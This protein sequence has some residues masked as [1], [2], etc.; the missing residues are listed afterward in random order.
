MIEQMHKQEK[1]KKGN[2][3]F[4]QLLELLE[5]PDT[6]EV[7]V[8]V[9]VCDLE[10]E[11]IELLE[12]AGA[13]KKSGEVVLGIG[14]LPLLAAGQKKVMAALESAA[15]LQRNVDGCLLV[16]KE[17]LI[18]PHRWFGTHIEHLIEGIESDLKR[19]LVDI[20]S[21][22]CPSIDNSV[23]RDTLRDCGTFVS[24]RG[25]GYGFNRV[26]LAFIE[27]LD[28]ASVFRFDMMTAR[29]VI[30]KIL[31]PA[32]TALTEDETKKLHHL[33]S[34]FP[35]TTDLILGVSTVNDAKQ[36]LE[37]IMLGTGVEIRMTN[38]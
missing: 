36:P 5:V 38:K 16:N 11:D 22:G 29:R 17:R 37:I 34:T 8:K 31:L 21:P 30:V 23:L 27:A 6:P 12:L 2:I 20:L 18:S 1:G 14:I 4:S 24:A 25:K 19:S 33:M 10:E 35:K 3:T 15:L 28:R 32:Q 13:V 7:G 26:E 9:F